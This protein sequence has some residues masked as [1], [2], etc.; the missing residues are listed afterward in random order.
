MPAKKIVLA[1]EPALLAILENSFF[2]REGFELVPV[3]DGQT[4]YQAVEAEAPSLALLDLALLGD[5]ALACCRGIKQDRLLAATPVLLIL[6]AKASDEEA[7]ACWQAGCDAVVHRPLAAE[8]FLD[9]AC[10]L[11]RISRRLEPRLPVNLP[12]AFVDARRKRHQARCV[13]LNSGGMFLAT[14]SLFPVNT[15]LALEFTPP[16]TAQGLQTDVRVAWVNHP[17]W[18]KKISLPCGMGVQLLSPDQAVMAALQTLL[19]S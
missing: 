17:E 12:V 10:G 19:D 5:Q 11:L 16:G 2:Q 3:K 15:T 14:T 9:A 7:D 4:G 13:N 18:R 8:R 6:P 1:S